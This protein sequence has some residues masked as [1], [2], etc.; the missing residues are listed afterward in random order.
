MSLLQ[1]KNL[2]VEFPTRRGTLRA[3]DDISFDIA[4]GEILGVVG[5][6][7]AGK[8]LT[9]ASIIGL[10]E[11]P[12]RVAS[13]QIL[14]EGQRIDNLPHEQMRKVRGR[15][16]GAIFQDPLTSLNPLYSVGR[17]LIET[18]TTHLP[19]SQV[20]ARERAIQLL[21]D[22]G[23]PAAEQRIDHYPHQ[24][25]GGMR[26]RVV[27]AL[28]LAAEPQLIVADEPTTALDVSIQA[29]IITLLKTICKERGAAVMLIT[30]DM[31]VI[32]ETCDRV[33][34]MY[35]GRVAEIGPVHDVINHPAHPYTKGLMACIPDMTADR[36]RLHQIDGA[37]PRLN[38]IPKG[39]AY[40]PRCDRGFDRCHE[41]RPDLMPAG[42][43]Q[44]ACWLHDASSMLTTGEAA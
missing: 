8:S 25:S 20:E 34:V 16:I 39:C 26:Q 1:V 10:L 11:P 29:Q 19:V 38:A 15:K 44:A 35:A 33:A 24:F 36:E 9:G 6:S 22:T 7:G 12:G 17:Q 27:I 3:L 5:E 21:R 14:L 37:M 23:I 42:A 30:H 43:T 32:A 41:Q 31:G 18:I 40:N 13:G 4:P 28:A 2:V